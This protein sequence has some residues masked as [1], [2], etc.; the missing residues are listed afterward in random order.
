MRILNAA[1]R[2]FALNS[3]DRV[4]VPEIAH[5]A[6]I[7]A[8]AIYK[9][10]ASKDEL[11]FEI[12]SRAVDTAPMPQ[13][14]GPASPGDLP[15]SIAAYATP[16]LSLV[17]RLAVEVHHAASQHPKVRALLLKAIEHRVQEIGAAIRAD[18]PSRTGDVSMTAHAVIVFVLGLM[19]MES[20]APQLIGD[21]AW[22][23]TIA[24]SVRALLVAK[25]KSKG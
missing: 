14:Q 8:G 10:F 16:E 22:Q 4:S 21:T 1:E 17:R 6:G 3:F 5:A 24:D 13:V 18:Q 20:L 11:F 25:P 19:H 15:R 2:L 9:H 12:V 7:T 23:S